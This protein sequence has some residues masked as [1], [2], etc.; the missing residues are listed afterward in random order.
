M[1]LRTVQFALVAMT[2]VITSR[3]V[4][5]VE[6]DAPQTLI[7]QEEAIM[8]GVQMKLRALPET[9]EFGESADRSALSDYYATRARSTLWVDSNGLT[10]RAKKLVEEISKGNS[11]GLDV[12]QFDLPSRS[13]SADGKAKLIDDELRVSLAVLKYARHARGGRMDPKELSLDIDRVPP[14]EDPRTVLTNLLQSPNPVAYLRN[15]HPKH[16]QFERLR[17]AYIR[18]LQDE[19]GSTSK[20]VDFAKTDKKPVRKPR[21]RSTQQLSKRLLYNMEMWRWMPRQLGTRYIR[22]NVP[23]YMI[24]VVDGDQVV[25]EE[26]MVVGKVKNKTPMFSDEME[27]IVFHPFWGVPN[28]IKVK[29][30][31]PGLVRG[32]NVLEKQ[33]LKIKYRGREINPRSVDWRTTDIRRY[34]VYQPP[35]SRNALGIVKFLFPNRH[36]IYFH[37][38]PSKQLFKRKTRAYSHG[39]MRVRDPLKLAEVLLGPDKGW[40][41]SKINALVRSGPKNN[42]ISLGKKVPVH[43]TYFTASIDDRGRLSLFKDIYGHEKRIQMGLDGKAHLIAKPKRDLS[44]ARRRVIST[45][46]SNVNTNVARRSPRDQ[47]WR[48][49]VWGN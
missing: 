44:V 21:A 30:L 41:R 1:K 27:T 39:C 3:S 10:D 13:I 2:I 11:W 40:G 49:Q 25:H 18:A 29:E 42:Q 26:R 37:D 8:L 16:T 35:S 20:T 23:E 45:V 33:G 34:D 22:A 46:T 48:R 6:P 14:L 5:A 47:S 28:S 31:L 4:W 24:R 43:I 7:T 19:R 17:T 36:A 38:T 12:S 9:K 32:S 15:L